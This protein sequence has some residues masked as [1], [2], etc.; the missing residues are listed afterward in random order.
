MTSRINGVFQNEDNDPP[1]KRAKL[2]ADNK[3]GGEENDGDDDDENV[4]GVFPI[5]PQLSVTF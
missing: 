5:N 1:E 3:D 2:D 4:R